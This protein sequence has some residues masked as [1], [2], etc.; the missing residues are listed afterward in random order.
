[1]LLEQWLL[2]AGVKLGIR[3]VYNSLASF[4]ATGGVANLE[5]V[6]SSCVARAMAF[7]STKHCSIALTPLLQKQVSKTHDHMQ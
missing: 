7:R 6:C 2:S 5:R 3:V 4:A 1:M